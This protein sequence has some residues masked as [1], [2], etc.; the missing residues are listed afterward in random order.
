MSEENLL[1]SA[2][3]EQEEIQT[4]VD[5]R[6]PLSKLKEAQKAATNENPENAKVS[7][8]LAGQD[9][10]QMSD[11][12]KRKYRAFVEKA[13]K[14]KP[15]R[16]LRVSFIGGTLEVQKKVRQYADEWSKFVNIKFDFVSQN[17]DIRVAFIK[18][19]SWSYIGTDCLTIP[20]SQPTMNF[21]WFDKPVTE[22]EFSRVILHEFGH[23]LPMPHEHSHPANGIP[24]NKEAVYRYYQGP[25]NNWTKAQVD[26]NMFA[27]YNQTRTQFS[28]FDKK[29]IMLYPIPKQFVTDPK[30]TVGMNYK[31]SKTDKY[32]M[33]NIYPK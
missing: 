15:G 16:I 23:A 19:G 10:D 30:F 17:G 5:V 2:E 14:W 31:L 20:Q 13:K 6:L 9:V 25:P 26:N 28:S 21:G 24:W 29:S 27:K 1:P 12:Q 22:D 32:F 4:C 7:Q 11:E 8:E 18:D 33:R 3:D